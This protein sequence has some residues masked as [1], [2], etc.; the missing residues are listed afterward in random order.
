[1]LRVINFD[2]ISAIVEKNPGRFRLNSSEVVLRRSFVQQTREEIGTMKDRA[3]IT[4]GQGYDHSARQ[5]RRI[6]T[7]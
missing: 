7:S 2:C 3:Q 4:R 5:V 6:I 1:M